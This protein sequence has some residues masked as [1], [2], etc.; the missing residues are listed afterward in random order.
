MYRCTCSFW[1]NFHFVTCFCF[2]ISGFL[3]LYVVLL[4][5]CQKLAWFRYVTQQDTRSKMV[6]LGTVVEEEGVENPGM[7]ISNNGT[8]FWFPHL[9][10]ILRTDSGGKLWLPMIPSWHPYD[11]RLGLCKM[12]WMS[13]SFFSWKKTFK[14][15]NYREWS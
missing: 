3:L 2:F 4:L 14:K 9:C 11:P 13:V 1:L 6:L 15:M 7:I 5:K 8:T 10:A 12:R